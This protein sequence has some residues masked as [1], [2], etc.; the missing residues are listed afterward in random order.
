MNVLIVNGFGNS[1][2]GQKIFCEFV[3]NIKTVY[4][5]LY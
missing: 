5:D 2:Q 1:I 3:L 4:S